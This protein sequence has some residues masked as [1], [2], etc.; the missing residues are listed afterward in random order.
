MYTNDEYLTEVARFAYPADAATPVA[1]LESEGIRC[2]MHNA[3]SSRVMGFVD[4]GGTRLQVMEN[5]ASRAIEILIEGGYERF[6]YK[7]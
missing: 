4:V 2:F 5:D 3:F 6:I 7:K 1:L